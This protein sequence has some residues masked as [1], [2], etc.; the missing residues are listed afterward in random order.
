MEENNVHIARYSGLKLKDYMA[1]ACGDL[2][3][4]LGFT[5][6]S[7]LIQTYYTD[8]L[9]LHPLF[10]MI[11]FVLAR[12]WDGIN[13]PMMG[14]ICDRM[15][16]NRFGKYK[17]W[18]LYGAIPFAAT[19]FLMF[20]KWPGFGVTP[21]NVWVYIYATVTYVLFGMAMTAI[22]IPYGS[23]A[24]VVT[25][26]QKE[27]SKLSI[28]RSIGS[29]IGSLPVILV[30]SLAFKSTGVD[31]TV[32]IIGISI[33]S[34]L[35]ILFLMLAFLGNKER[36]PIP[37]PQPRV[38]GAMRAGIKRIFSTR[39]M[40][41][42]CIISAIFLA[43]S[44]FSTGYY[45]YIIRQYFNRSGF[46]TMLPSFFVV[47]VAFILMFFLQKITYKFGKKEVCT[48][49]M[50][51]A[52]IANL[53]MLFLLNKG[54]ST[55]ILVGFFILNFLSCF[56][57]GVLNMAVWGMATDA[58]DDIQLKHGIREDGTSYALF[59]FFRKCGQALSAI[60]INGSLLAFGYSY[61]PGE[62]AHFTSEQLQT[63]FILASVI[64]AA[65]YG[66]CTVLFIFWFPINKKRL[67][68]IEQEKEKFLSRDNIKIKG[69]IYKSKKIG[70]D[71]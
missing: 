59:M 22:Q 10:V 44:M 47:L 3:I 21:T 54:I 28:W 4:C 67:M 61:N 71:K 49:G 14:R 27:R 62:K 17:R 31:Y 40:I 37:E 53:C 24:S 19:I 26:N 32:L 39:S 45:T 52:A 65:L 29:S 51:L 56:G 55:G 7:A 42:I 58:I 36:A 16:P 33:M 15:K 25:L 60:T 43:G 38:K 66:V 23:L 50:A 13:D 6:Q 68:E 18:F 34:A 1:Y 41:A 8:C 11:M 64:P 12:I 46:L 35:A 69:P 2:G 9:L 48:V 20:I 5:L 70:N 57:S 30:S 63:M